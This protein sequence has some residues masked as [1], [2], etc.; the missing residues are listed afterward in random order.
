MKTRLIFAMLSTVL[1]LILLCAC[2]PVAA[3][4]GEQVNS[5]TEAQTEA[6]REAEYSVTA[7][8]T[9][10]K[11]VIDSIV[12]Q[13]C[14]TWE[15]TTVSDADEISDIVDMIN[16]IT[17]SYTRMTTAGSYDSRV[18]IVFFNEYGGE[19]YRSITLHNDKRCA[20]KVNRKSYYETGALDLSIYDMENGLG[21]YEAVMAYLP[22]EQ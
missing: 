13:D 4:D 6:P 1:I 12:I 7:F 8:D 2:A 16:G 5:G 14:N 18:S 22:I 11:S 9:M 20:Y 15:S 21:L 3:P 19:C 10:D 17:L